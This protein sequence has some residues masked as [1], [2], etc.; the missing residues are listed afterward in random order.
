MGL[1]NGFVLRSKSNQNLS[2]EIASFRNYYELNSWM[3]HR[4]VEFDDPSFAV[5][6]DV[7][8]E[9]EQDI[10]NIARELL[11][12]SDS[13]IDYYEDN[14]WPQELEEKFYGK[15]FDPTHSHS[16]FAPHKLVRLYR[17]VLCIR[18]ILENNS[19]MHITFYS[20]Y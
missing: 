20:S 19:G 1:D 9:L 5:P 3:C 10:E 17:T 6:D 16:A 15:E 11:K 2:I 13:Q 14:G 18:E 7:L 4:C 8:I 12:L